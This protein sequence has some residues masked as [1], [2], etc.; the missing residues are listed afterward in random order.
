MNG[1]YNSQFST[2]QNQASQYPNYQ[3]VP[4]ENSQY[5][6]NCTAHKS[7]YP[8]N[9]PYPP[10]P[11]PQIKPPCVYDKKDRIFA[12]ASFVLGF[13][14][15]KVLIGSLGDFGF[16]AAFVLAAITVFNFLYTKSLGLKITKGQGAAYVVT[17]LLAV[18][19]VITDNNNLKSLDLSLAV[20]TNLYLVYTSYKTGSHSVA[21]NTLKAIFVSPFEQYASAFGALFHRNKDKAEK[22]K[23][24]SNV[25]YIVVGLLLSIPVTIVVGLLLISSDDNF[26]RF[27]SDFCKSFLSSFFKN[28]FIFA[29]SLPIGM[30]I[31]S[32]VYSRNYEKTNKEKLVKTPSTNFRILPSPLCN[33]FLTPLCVLY[34]FYIFWQLSYFFKTMGGIE[35]ETFDY[36]TYAREG[37]FQLCAVAVINFALVFFV[38]FM[39]KLEKKTLPKAVRVYLCVFSVLTLCLIVTALVK[40]MM[41]ITMYGFTPKRVYT[42]VFMVYLFALFVLLIVKQLKCRISFT[43]IAYCAAVVI[44]ICMSVMPVDGLI[45]KYNINCYEQGKIDWMG[46]S[47]LRQLDYS[48]VRYLE[49][50][51]DTNQDVE[52]YF[53]HLSQQDGM[54]I[55][56][57]NFTRYNAEKIISDAVK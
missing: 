38:M 6:Q 16:A 22:G 19:L 21:W 35:S 36:S 7:G 37:F 33:A 15:L 12:A 52:R 49:P 42:S 41:Y 51:A 39:T 25:G 48:A 18:M 1:Q 34:V 43:K 8:G 10:P 26:Y 46:Y 55:Y 23:K 20:I 4:P 53:E 3:S 17:L 27:Y 9:P 14:V 56:T 11:P 2:D 44:L 47:A 28:I 30:Y 57:F 31:F 32:A 29:C 50:I 40:M 13:L 45:A 24:N 54:D 5:S